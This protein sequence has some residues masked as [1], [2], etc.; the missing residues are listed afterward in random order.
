MLFTKHNLVGQWDAEQS[1]ERLFFDNV[2][3]MREKWGKDGEQFPD[4]VRKQF[5]KAMEEFDLL[6][7]ILRQTM[8][9]ETKLLKISSITKITRLVAA[10]LWKQKSG[11]SI[12]SD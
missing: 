12:Q 6:R 3:R 2:I 10:A 11:V 5:F 4:V 8:N 9:S 7:V 1:A